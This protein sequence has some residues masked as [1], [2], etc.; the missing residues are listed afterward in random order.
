MRHLLAVLV[1]SVMKPIVLRMQQAALSA[2]AYCLSAMT[3]HRHHR[4]KWQ[5][6]NHHVTCI[7]VVAVVL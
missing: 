5:A 2:A 6:A 4:P 1:I 7:S 3:C